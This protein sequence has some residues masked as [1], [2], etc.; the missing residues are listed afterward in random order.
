MPSEVAWI[1][2]GAPGSVAGI[3][4]YARG[5]MRVLARRT[6]RVVPAGVSTASALGG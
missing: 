5:R 1:A 2:R 3:P 6:Y 4:E